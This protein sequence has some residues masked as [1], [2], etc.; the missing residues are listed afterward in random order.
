VSPPEIPTSFN[1]TDSATFAAAL[2]S[3]RSGNA[4]YF[5]ITVKA[6]INL[7]LQDLTLGGYKDKT[8]ALKGDSTARAINLAGT[9]SLFTVGSG[10]T[11]ELEGITLEGIGTS[12]GWNNASLINVQAYG[13]LNINEGAKIINN[14]FCETSAHGGGV[15]VGSNAALY[16]NGGEISG[17]VSVGSTSFDS[18]SCGGG[19]YVDSGGN[20]VMGGGKIS[21]NY[22][23]SDRTISRGGG[24]YLAGGASFTMNSGEISAN[25]LD[26]NPNFADPSSEGMGVYAA[27]GASFTMNNGEISGNVNSDRSGNGAGVWSAG[28]FTM[29]GGKIQGNHFGSDTNTS[30][31]YGGGVY[32]DG[33]TFT[34]QP[35]GAIYGSNADD[36]LQNTARND[37]RGHAVYVK[38]GGK[39]RNST[40]GEGVTLDSTKEDA[41]GGWIDPLPGNLSLGESLTW[42]DTNAAD[43]GAYTLTVNANETVAPKTLSYG[44]KKVK[45]TLKGDSPTRTYSLAGTGSLF[46]VGSGVTLELEDITLQGRSDNTAP[47]VKV[48]TDGKL[49]VK[50]GGRITGNTYTTS[51]NDTGG[52]G[53]FVSGGELEIAGGE[54]SGNTITGSTQSGHGGGVLVDNGSVVMTGGAIRENRITN[55]HSGDGNGAGGGIYINNNSSFEMLDGKIEGNIVNTRSTTLGNGA[56]GAGVAVWNS[57]FHLGGGVIRNNT[58]T[59]Q[60]ANIYSSSW[61]GGISI[62]ADT[63]STF[64]MDGGIIS[65]NSLASST[66]PNTTYFSGRYRIGAFGGGV[67]IA[68]WGGSCTMTKTGGIIYGNDVSGSDADGYPLKNTAQSDG[69]GAGG[70]HA[71]WMDILNNTTTYRRNATAYAANNMSRSQS[72][73]AGGWE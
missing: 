33:G 73:S 63:A 37:S 70:G 35:G 23:G 28:T 50:T 45:L 11:L 56:H 65:G 68:E 15:Y 53:V 72:G 42:L 34:K 4:G 66:N 13:Q 54:I 36:A 43:G 16:M 62:Q 1:V 27:A 3:I 25:S 46:T 55:T 19:V 61:G 39:K 26:H 30:T 41:A 21:D 40:A 9:G 14:G 20:F 57:Y 5:T 10:V 58:G 17:N 32:V 60:A 49:A 7:G 6:D 31:G 64:V 2:A 38:E 67:G 52:A 24:V 48:E 29:K 12:A 47:L 51:V 22:A 71:V 69:G 59:S 8:I 18:Y 44:G